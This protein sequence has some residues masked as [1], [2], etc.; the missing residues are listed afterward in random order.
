MRFSQTELAGAYVLDLEIRDDARGFFAR[1]FCQKEFEERGLKPMVAQ[2]NCSYNFKRGT[3]RGIHSRLPR[4]AKT[5][6]TRCTR[7]AVYDVFF[8]MPP[9]SRPFPQHIGVKLS[10]KNRR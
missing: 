4:G 6:L 10:K 9:H 3:L 8:D 7:G 2:C 1:S 5:K